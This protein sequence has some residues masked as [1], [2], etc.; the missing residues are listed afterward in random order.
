MAKPFDK[1]ELRVRLRAGQRIIELEQN[2]ADRNRE[3]VSA[4]ERM[5][6]NLQA[7]ATVQQAFLPAQDPKIEG[8]DFAWRFKP[9]DELAGDMLNILPLDNEHIG[10]Y[11]LDVSGHGVRAALLSITLHR[12]LSR[13][14]DPA[15]VLKQRIEGSLRYLLIPPAEVAKQL[16]LRFPWDPLTEQFFTIL[17]GIL[18]V[19]SGQ[20]CYVSAGHP[21]PI[22]VKNDAEPTILVGEG[23]P[24]GVKDEDYK[25]HSVILKPGDRLFLYSDGITDAMNSK[26]Q[27]FGVSRFIQAID[28]T[29]SIPLNNSVSSLLESVEEWCGDAP[30][31]DDISL[32]AAEL[33]S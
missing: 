7:A 9:C 25:E 11:V 3:L 22:H 30:L 6:R 32:L 14:P 4:N 26:K 24:I 2:L 23:F 12:F 17:Y 20:F 28:Q 13:M 29:R 19:Q 1:D 10:L 31:R 8:V 18:N 15:S 33:R 27:L 5:F 16:N 21:T